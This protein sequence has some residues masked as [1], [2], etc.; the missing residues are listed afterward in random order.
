MLGVD[1]AG[2]GDVAVARAVGQGHVVVV[3][4]ARVGVDARV[5]DACAFRVAINIFGATCIRGFRGIH[6][7]IKVCADG[8][9]R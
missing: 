9:C 4:E 6:R 2:R 7:L 5:R 3:E 1:A 8:T